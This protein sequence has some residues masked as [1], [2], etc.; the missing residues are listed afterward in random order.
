MAAESEEKNKT[1]HILGKVIYY[2]VAVVAGLG[3]ALLAFIWVSQ[4]MR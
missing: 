1:L 3:G 2:T 4:N